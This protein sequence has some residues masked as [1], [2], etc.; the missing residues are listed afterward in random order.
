MLQKEKLENSSRR[1]RSLRDLLPSTA[2]PPKTYVDQDGRERYQST[3]RLKAAAKK[4]AKKVD[5]V[6]VYGKYALM[7][8]NLMPKGRAAY[9]RDRPGQKAAWTRSPWALV[10]SQ[11]KR[12]LDLKVNNYGR[13]SLY[14]MLTTKPTG[15]VKPRDSKG[16]FVAARGSGSFS[17]NVGRKAASTYREQSVSSRANGRWSYRRRSVASDR[18]VG[19]FTTTGQLLTMLESQIR[20]LAVRGVVTGRSCRD[21]I[22]ALNLE[23]GSLKCVNSLVRGIQGTSTSSTIP[24]EGEENPPS[25][26]SCAATE[27]DASCPPS[28]I[29][30]ASCE[31]SAVS[32]FRSATSWTF[33]GR[34]GGTAPSGASSSGG[35][36]R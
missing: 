28:T 8:G 26:E 33:P 5:K 12:G 13:G 11:K 20:E 22:A 10:Q 35:S 9:G 36:S 30:R 32:R 17:W 23:P 29:T 15:C 19:L 1:C 18:V 4:P 14:S 24:S 27:K 31:P 6:G 7:T 34:W 3:G 21:N 25:L 2:M 16:R